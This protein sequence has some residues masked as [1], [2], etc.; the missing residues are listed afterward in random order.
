MFLLPPDANAAAETRMHAF[1]DQS[2]EE[3]YREIESDLEW[4][5]ISYGEAM[6]FT[7]NQMHG[8]RINREPETR[9]SINCRFKGLFTPYAGKRLGEFFEP[10][11]IRPATRLGMNYQLRAMP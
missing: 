3:L 8:N 11:T 6:V 7:Q 4:I 10:I 9:W 2:A 5:E 1:H